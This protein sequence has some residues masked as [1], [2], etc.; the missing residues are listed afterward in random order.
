MVIRTLLSYMSCLILCLCLNLG[1]V[2][3]FFTILVGKRR[4]MEIFCYNF[5]MS[6]LC[7][8]KTDKLILFIVYIWCAKILGSLFRCLFPFFEFILQAT[9]ISIFIC[10]EKYGIVLFNYALM[11]LEKN[12][13]FTF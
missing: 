9:A 1:K 11:A 12:I 6:I 10:S 13:K 3:Q 2:N 7:S 5:I 8:M 4:N